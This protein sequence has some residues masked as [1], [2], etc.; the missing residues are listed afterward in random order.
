[1]MAA[2]HDTHIGVEGCVRRARESMFW[3]RMAT[4]LKTYIS[5]CDVCL[6]HCAAPPKETLLPHEFTPRRW[7]KVGA[8]LCKLNDWTLLVVCDY[9]SN[10]IEVENLQTTTTRAVCK[11]LKILFARYGVPDTLVTDN[12]PQFS[13]AEFLMF[14][15]AWSF[16]H[17]T[18][19]LHYPQSNGKAE[20]AVKTVKRL[21]TKCR[22]AR[23]SEYRAL[24][25][26]WNTPTEGVGTSPAQRF[27]GR[28][29]KTL[30]LMTHSQLEPHYPTANDAQ[31]LM[32]HRAKQQYCYN[33]NAKDSYPYPEVTQSGCAF[34]DRLRGLLVSALASMDLEATAS[35]WVPGSSIAI[36]DSCYTQ[37]NRGPRSRQT[38]SQMGRV[39]QPVGK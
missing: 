17:S 24:L 35:E 12:G 37:R 16:E 20:N 29:C 1:M 34:R 8:D 39:H 33:R 2:C 4:D 30:L 28:R 10:F 9:Y 11:A 36:G 6:A 18:S 13:S 15:K 19:S 22:E 31:A 23:Q 38:L 14:T 21:F 5:K 32:G 25:D 7:S 3:P 26:W 27:L